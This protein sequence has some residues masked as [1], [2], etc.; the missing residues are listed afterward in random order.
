[1]LKRVYRMQKKASFRSVFAHGKSYPS[2]YVVIYIFQQSP[3]RYGFIAS[4]KVG[5]AVKR[6]RAKRLLREAVRLNLSGLK[7]DY[8]MILI[9][10][11][12]IINASLEEVQ[13]T[14]IN[15]WKRAGIFYE[16][17]S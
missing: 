10:R 3:V 6:N 12:A 14:I 7:K 5:N 2:R 8:Q 16:K 9:A 11:G 4:K 15:I 1:M 17:N 13:K